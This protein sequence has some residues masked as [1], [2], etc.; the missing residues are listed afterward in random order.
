MMMQ[1]GM[2]PMQGPPMGK[3]GP[4]KMRCGGKGC[5]KGRFDRGP[6]MDS[7]MML[8]I[9]NPAKA[10][11]LKKLKESNPEEFG[12][13]LRSA[14]KEMFEK[15]KT[16]MNEYKKLVREYRKN[17]N[18]DL[19]EKIRASLLE[20]Y[21]VNLKIKEKML[22]KMQEKAKKAQEDLEQAKSLKDKLVDMKLELLTLPPDLKDW[23]KMGCGGP[24]G[25]SGPKGP[26]CP[27]GK[28]GPKGEKPQGPPT[29]K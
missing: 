28:G 3:G 6:K 22:Q 19:Q 2:R 4:D 8:E 20:Q 21:D 9:E 23:V 26:G 10:E 7:L 13:A 18:S 17:K 25:K 29:A 11:E 12:K 24:K 15:I 1:Q 27:G 14:E 16:K 5:G